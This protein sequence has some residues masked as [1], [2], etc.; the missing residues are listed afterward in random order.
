MIPVSSGKPC[1]VEGGCKNLQ[2]PLVEMTMCP[3]MYT[4]YTHSS[5]RDW[6]HAYCGRNGCIRRGSG[7]VPAGTGVQQSVGEPPSGGLVSAARASAAGQA[8]LNTSQCAA[9]GRCNQGGHVAL[10]GR[11]HSCE[12]PC[13]LVCMQVVNEGHACTSCRPEQAGGA[14][15]GEASKGKGKNRTPQAD[16]HTATSTTASSAAIS[17]PCD[18][19]L[20]GG[21]YASSR[22]SPP[23]PGHNA[24]LECDGRSSKAEDIE[25]PQE[26]LDG[27]AKSDLAKTVKDI[28][29][30]ILSK[31]VEDRLFEEAVLKKVEKKKPDV[32][33]TKKALDKVVT[34][35]GACV[36]GILKSSLAP[37]LQ[38]ATKS[39]TSATTKLKEGLE[40]A[41]GAATGTAGKK[42]PAKG[43]KATAGAADK[44]N[45]STPSKVTLDG[46][47]HAKLVDDVAAKVYGLIEPRLMAMAQY[48]VRTVSGSQPAATPPDPT[49]IRR[50]KKAPSKSSRS[51]KHRKVPSPSP[52]S[53]DPSSSS[54]DA[55]TPSPPKKQKRGRPKCVEDGFVWLRFRCRCSASLGWTIFRSQEN[56]WLPPCNTCCSL[57]FAVD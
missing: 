18:P 49:P 26:G 8:I 33:P 11:C 42:T 23:G 13:H 29:K 50:S 46:T 56:G 54:S 57:S 47:Q 41:A 52:S 20:D 44:E 3:G 40:Q 36:L 45:G 1:H 48:I 31:A 53:T 5:C 35:N 30:E 19:R 4:H 34:A 51:K 16:P 2:A 28:L 14:N 38:A 22:K 17:T 7:A 9:G 27:Y 24:D 55:E 32:H 39:L 25:L 43:K 10:S 6:D 12:A 37:E 21:V 15:G